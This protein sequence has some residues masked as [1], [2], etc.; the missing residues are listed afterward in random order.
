MTS[1]CA[2]NVPV[3]EAHRELDCLRAAQRGAS[4]V[5]L[6]GH[7][8]GISNSK[9]VPVVLTNTSGKWGTVTDEDG[10]YRFDNIAKGPYTI[11]VPW[12]TRAPQARSV[13]VLVN[14]CEVQD[15]HVQG[16]G[17]VSGTITVPDGARARVSMLL[18][19]R[20][21]QEPIP[22]YPALPSFSAQNVPTGEYV[23]GADIR[24]TH[25]WFGHSERIYYP[26]T[27]TIG[28][29][30]VIRV[31]PGQQITGLHWKIDPEPTR[32]IEVKVAGGYVR[33]S[34][35]VLTEIVSGEDVER[36]AVGG[37]IA[38][39]VLRNRSY[40]LVAQYRDGILYKHSEA[41]DISEGGDRSIVLDASHPGFVNECA[42]CRSVM[43]Q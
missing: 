12:P 22:I 19:D 32:V 11:S 42:R 38:I 43:R 37:R 18:I 8:R 25:D 13:F 20:K 24:A 2:G 26:G 1:M 3:S 14:A 39:T 30:K 23:L 28:Q 27:G 33:V 16:S 17:R 40:R 31:G 21:L 7:V 35:I 4:P 9:G 10:N 29:A 36:L 5:R 6:T 34:S 15:M 41:V